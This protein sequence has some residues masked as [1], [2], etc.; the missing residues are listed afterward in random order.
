R[1][2]FIG[3][4]SHERENIFLT[5]TE[6]KNLRYQ[7]ASSICILIFEMFILLRVISFSF[8]N[9]D[10]DDANQSNVEIYEMLKMG[11]VVHFVIPLRSA[12]F[13]SIIITTIPITNWFLFNF[14]SSFDIHRMPVFQ[15]LRDE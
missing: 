9:Y 5:A 11:N 2:G 6:K 13:T 3:L 4:F 8:M 12:H 14:N 7:R 15:Y 10:D 1:L